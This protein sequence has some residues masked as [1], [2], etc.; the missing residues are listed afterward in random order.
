MRTFA[1]QSVHGMALSAASLTTSYSSAWHSHNMTYYWIGENY[2]RIFVIICVQH[3]VEMCLKLV[4]WLFEGTNT[5]II[6]NDCT[7]SKDGESWL[8]CSTYQHQHLGDDPA[9][10]QH[11][12]AFLREP[13]GHRAVLHPFGQ[14]HER[15]FWSS[16]LRGWERLKVLSPCFLS[17]PPVWD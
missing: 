3:K 12:K 6:H 1:Y 14:D 8:F 2:P 17:L 10:L 7:S 11:H 13:C 5:L 4:R 16:W 9:A 15:N